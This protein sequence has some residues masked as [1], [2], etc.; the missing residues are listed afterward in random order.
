MLTETD[1]QLQEMRIGAAT[2]VI[3]AVGVGSW[4]QAVAMHYKSPSKSPSATVIAVEPDTAASLKT[5]LEAGKITPI[6]TGTTIMNGMNCG[7][8]STTAW[9]VLKESVDV[10]VTVSD[11]KVHHDLQY[12]H[13]QGVRNG[14]CGASVYTALLNLCKEAGHMLSLDK[15]SVVVLFSTEGARDYIVPTGA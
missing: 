6:A 10:S 3:A 11:I 5:S 2:H 12:L 13:A 4:L 8:T 1:K 7:T 15:K 9:T 14:P